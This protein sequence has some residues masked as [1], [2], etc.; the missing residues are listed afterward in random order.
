M[1]YVNTMDLIVLHIKVKCHLCTSLLSRMSTQKPL[2]SVVYTA[3]LT[4]PQKKE[5]YK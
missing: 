4:K 3:D 2:W 5:V 1:L